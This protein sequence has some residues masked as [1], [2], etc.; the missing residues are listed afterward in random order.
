[1]PKDDKIK[2][3]KSKIYRI[4]RF[5]TPWTATIL[6]LLFS[7]PSKLPS[8]V[9]IAPFILLFISIYV[10]VI[11]VMDLLR[12]GEQNKIVGMRAAK[13]R[14]VAALIACFPILLLVLQSIG[15]LTA[16]DIL[17]AVAI[18]IVAYFYILKS[19]TASLGR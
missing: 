8:A 14:L 1:M 7:N 17:T 3:M 2:G 12:G 9:L 15:Q 5:V 6:L 19:S 4:L 10:T 18:F 16:W 11:E 13:P